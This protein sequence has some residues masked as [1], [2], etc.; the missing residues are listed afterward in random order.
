MSEQVYNVFPGD[1]IS[2]PE[3]KNLLFKDIKDLSPFCGFYVNP[4][5]GIPG[6][7]GIQ[8]FGLENFGMTQ[9]STIGNTRIRKTW[10]YRHTI[11]PDSKFVVLHT[12]LNCQLNKS[13]YEGF[14]SEYPLTVLAKMIHQTES[15][16][17]MYDPL[18]IVIEFNMYSQRNLHEVNC[19][20]LHGQL[21]ILFNEFDKISLLPY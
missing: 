9:G 18:G 6:E 13:M 12:F 15:G 16:S 8:Q 3:F 19:V 4:T 11:D 17:F 5:V 2:S 7:D 20:N 14:D 10:N 1:I 21:N